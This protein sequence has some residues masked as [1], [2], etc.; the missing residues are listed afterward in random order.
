MCQWLTIM[1]EAVIGCSGGPM[2][3]LPEKR[4]QKLFESVRDVLYTISPDGVITS[5]NAAFETLTGWPREEWLGRH[6]QDLIHPDDVPA[7][8]EKNQQALEGWSPPLCT[9]RIR[10]RS[11]QYKFTECLSTQE[12]ADH[13]PI[14]VLGVVRDVSQ[15]MLTEQVLRE[16]EERFRQVVENIRNVF[17]LSDPSKDQMIYVSPGY[18]EIWGRTRASL[19]ASPRSWLDAIHPD[20]RLRVTE[21]ALS[22]QTEGGYEETYRIVRPDGSIRWI[23]DRAFPIR[24]GSGQVYRISG[25]AVDITKHKLCEDD[26]HELAGQL[27]RIREEERTRISLD[28]HDQFG[29]T[30]ATMKLYLGWMMKSLSEKTLSDQLALW[31]SRLAVLNQDLDHALATVEKICFELRPA[32][33]DQLGLPSAVEAQAADFIKRTGIACNVD[34]ALGNT[35]VT[36]DH[37]TALFRV[38]QEALTNVAR[39]AHATRVQVRLREEESGVTLEVRDNGSGIDNAKIHDRHSLGLMGIRERLRPF[40]GHLTISNGDPGTSLIVWLPKP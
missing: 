22:Q 35:N 14:G 1:M 4:Y 28:L 26:L 3:T 32:A 40:G 36:S 27:E 31:Q 18:E 29:Q 30:L 10:T 15:R 2:E 21:A 7:M 19:Y 16:S 8:M 11:G 5:L 12:T 20:D 33:L 25:I 24:D 38:L 17:W 13:E 23:Q 34:F 39:H 37:A 6:V 9:V